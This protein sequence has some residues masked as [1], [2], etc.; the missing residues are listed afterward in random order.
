MKQFPKPEDSSKFLHPYWINAFLWITIFLSGSNVKYV[1]KQESHSF[2]SLTASTG[3]LIWLEEGLIHSQ[4]WAHMVRASLH[5][6]GSMRT[7]H[8]HSCTGL[9][10]PRAKLKHRSPS[11]RF[12]PQATFITYQ[13][14]HDSEERREEG[15]VCVCVGACVCV[16]VCVCVLFPFEEVPLCSPKDKLSPWGP[17]WPQTLL[18]V[19]V[20]VRGQCL[21]ERVRACEGVCVCEGAWS[22]TK[23]NPFPWYTCDEI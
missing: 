11:P 17:R 1:H 23:G 10:S 14:Q 18:F 12:S 21:Y 20:P 5:V 6:R 7:P 2:S 22:H 15:C 16:C 19:R 3:W 13:P 4:C 9:G 8:N